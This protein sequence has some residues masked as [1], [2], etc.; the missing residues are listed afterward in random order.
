[1]KD[2]KFDLLENGM[3]FVISSVE[4]IL[5]EEKGTKLKYSILHISSGLELILKECLKQE[6]WSLI[7]E[8][9]SKAQL[10]SLESGDFL[11][12]NLNTTINRLKNICKV[13]ISD[14]N[15]KYINDLKQRRN[16]IE[17]FKFEENSSSIVSL[18][19]KI[20]LFLLEFIDSEMESEKFSDHTKNQIWELSKQSS[21]FEEYIKL[22]LAKIKTYLEGKDPET[23]YKCPNCYQ[24]ALV[25]EGEIK[26]MF[27][28]YTDSPE[29]VAENYL[30]NVLRVSRYREISTGGEFPLYNC[31]DCE[32]GSLVIHSGLNF[33]FNCKKSFDDS[34]FDT[35]QYCGEI[36]SIENDICSD[37]MLSR[38]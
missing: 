14:K 9:T 6:H 25:V 5:N 17:H 16:R 18:I 15:I 36:C 38:W 30:E 24:D 29:K 28:N 20:L 3:D 8:D 37:C 23:I 2:L 32:N 11:S 31:I 7:F 26:C 21:K 35:C 19:A 12:V 1:M 27:C 10:E 4:P 34:A 13:E 33:C 22:R